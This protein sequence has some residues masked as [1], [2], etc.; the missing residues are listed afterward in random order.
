MC[1][2]RKGEGRESELLLGREYD[3]SLTGGR[4]HDDNVWE[5]VMSESGK[6]GSNHDDEYVVEWDDKYTNDFVVVYTLIG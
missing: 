5:D 4:N 1:G 3:E 2:E 6:S